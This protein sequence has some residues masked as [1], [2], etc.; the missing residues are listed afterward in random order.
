[1]G[2][3]F[4]MS[5]FPFIDADNGGNINGIITF[6]KS[7]LAEIND[8]TI[9]VPGHGPVSTPQDMQNYIQML[10][11]VRDRISRLIKNG[12]S[13]DEVLEAHPAQ[14]WEESFGDATMLV[15]RAYAGMTK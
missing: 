4:N 9:V 2:D 10:E 14:E 12:K 1:M 7:V 6:C 11:T 13:L 3:V 15:D 5:G 8:E